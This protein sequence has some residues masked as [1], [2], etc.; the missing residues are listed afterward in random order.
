MRATF[1]AERSSTKQT[2]N[3]NF[4]YDYYFLQS[5]IDIANNDWA[6]DKADDDDDDEDISAR[7]VSS[8]ELEMINLIRAVKRGRWTM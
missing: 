3:N 7:I 8:F 4:R 6:L 1:T 5:V 2:K